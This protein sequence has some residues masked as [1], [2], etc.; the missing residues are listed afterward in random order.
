MRNKQINWVDID[1]DGDNDLF[2]TS[3]NEGNRLYPKNSL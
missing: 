2:V 3:D 1:N